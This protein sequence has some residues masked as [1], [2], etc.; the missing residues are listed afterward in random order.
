MNRRWVTGLVILLI[1]SFSMP[2]Y[3][4]KVLQGRDFYD[5]VEVRKD[6]VVAPPGK[7]V[8]WVLV[9]N[10]RQYNATIFDIPTTLDCQGATVYLEPQPN[11][12]KG[13]DGW[14]LFM[15]RKGYIK[16]VVENPGVQGQCLVEIPCRSYDG[17]LRDVMPIRIVL[18][19]GE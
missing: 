18:L 10:H 14:R 19:K 17:R 9:W 6:R 12:Y 1:F 4:L 8:H 5:Y 2:V 7:S 13:S 16:V 11:F 15:K 3:G